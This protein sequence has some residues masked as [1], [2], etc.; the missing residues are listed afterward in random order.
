MYL[1]CIAT[2]VHTRLSV[3]R[4]HSHT[5]L[6]DLTSGLNYFAWLY[7][8]IIRDKRTFDRLRDV[9]LDEEGELYQ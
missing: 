9:V 7:L 3:H 4:I 1:R 8:S 6:S 2:T 5:F